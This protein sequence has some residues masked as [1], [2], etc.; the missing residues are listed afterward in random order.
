M[1]LVLGKKEGINAILG[2]FKTRREAST[3]EGIDAM[4]FD[5]E[6][7]D[8]EIIELPEEQPEQHEILLMEGC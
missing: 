4:E 2:V 6:G 3:F 7:V 5:S 1:F 8:Y